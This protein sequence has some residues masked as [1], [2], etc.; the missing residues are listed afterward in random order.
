MSCL[1]FSPDISPDFVLSDYEV[2]RTNDIEKACSIG[3]EILCDNDLK[4]SNCNSS[5]DASIFYRKVGSVGLGR[6]SYGGNVVISPNVFEDFL[7]VQMPIRGSEEITLGRERLL[8]T[9]EVFGIIN[10][11][12]KSTIDHKCNTEKL[13]IRI[14]KK[15]INRN[16][17]EILGY[18][19]T[20]DVEFESAMPIE[21]NSNVQWLKMISWIYSVVSSQTFLSSLMVAQ[22][23]NNIVNMLLDNQPNNYS[24][25]IHDEKFSI[26]PFFIK[27][28]E[29]YIHENAKKT[30]TIHDIAEDAGVSCRTIFNGFRKYKNITPMRY[31]KEVRLQNAYED[32][33]RGHIGK[34]TVTEIAFK[35]GFSHLGHFSND[36]KCRFYEAPSETLLR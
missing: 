14:D 6:M 16:C 10:S 33:K 27:K 7:L 22:I 34:D 23:E 3:G 29:R 17:Q 4:L 21:K 36:Y 8:C 20:K 13:I 2:C 12:T 19:L 15:L 28:V 30:I 35:W 24:S 31:L 26:S 18:T 5:I 1:S 9:P 32:L 25:E 11:N